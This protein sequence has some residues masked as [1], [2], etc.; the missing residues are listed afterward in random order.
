[1]EVNW[2]DVVD[3]LPDIPECRYAVNVLV[4]TTDDTYTSVYA[5]M[6]G[7]YSKSELFKASDGNEFMELYNGNGDS[8]WGPLQE[9][10]THWMYLP[11]PPRKDKI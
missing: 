10:V 9:K 7:K 8:F 2:V 4:V 3:K 6:Y 5:C 1:M 11:E